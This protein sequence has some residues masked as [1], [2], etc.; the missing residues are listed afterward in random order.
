MLVLCGRLLS[1]AKEMV[2]S[3]FLFFFHVHPRLR[4]CR[5]IMGQTDCLSE[6]VFVLVNCLSTIYHNTNNINQLISDTY[7]VEGIDKM[8]KTS[9]K[10]WP[11]P[12]QR[13]TEINDRGS[14]SIN[15]KKMV[16][17][18]ISKDIT[19]IRVRYKFRGAVVDM[20][21]YESLNQIS[22]QVRN[23]DTDGN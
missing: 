11:F 21:N 23:M 17:I 12:L 20:T 14:D 5:Q 18:I 7:S 19:K 22:I 8:D 4:V 2:G 3:L 6:F 13:A 16:I 9:W 15:L 10:H 1:G